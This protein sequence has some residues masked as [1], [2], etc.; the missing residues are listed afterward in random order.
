MKQ[1]VFRFAP[2]PNGHLHLGHALSALIDFEMARTM[3]GRFL[4]RMEDIDGTRCRPEFEQAIYEDLAW[5]GVTWEQPVRRQVVAEVAADQERELGKR[6]ATEH[7]AARQDGGLLLRDRGEVHVGVVQRVDGRQRQVQEIRRPLE[8]THHRSRARLGVLPRRRIHRRQA[9]VLEQ[10][11]EE[12]FV[13]LRVG[14]GRPQTPM[15][16]ADYVL[17][18]FSEEQ[19]RRLPEVV[20]RAADALEAIVLEGPL[21]AMNRFNA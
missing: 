2:S 14:I 3:N 1:P 13:R 20:D 18:A 6:L 10:L 19:A 7:A 12:N 5:L 11:G 15:D 16:P 9:A 21:V 17:Q 4:L 8:R